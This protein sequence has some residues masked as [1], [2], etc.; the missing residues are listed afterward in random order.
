MKTEGVVY[1]NYFFI[2]FFFGRKEGY[3][4]CIDESW[5][6]H[7]GAVEDSGLLEYDM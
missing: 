3:L 7:S 5:G 1:I 4:I 6:L 2:F